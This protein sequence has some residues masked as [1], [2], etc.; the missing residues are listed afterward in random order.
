MKNRKPNERTKLARY[1]ALI[2]TLSMTP[3]FLGEES[4]W[5][6]RLSV[7]KAMRMTSSMTFWKF[8][9]EEVFMLVTRSSMRSGGI[10]TLMPMVVILN[11]WV[12]YLSKGTSAARAIK[13]FER[14]TEMVPYK[15]A[16]FILPFNL[17]RRAI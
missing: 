3:L 14:N 7:A 8:S 4:S 12:T 1:M 16:L 10:T 6:L 17:L 15:A 13:I 9:S 5:A 2:T 11:S